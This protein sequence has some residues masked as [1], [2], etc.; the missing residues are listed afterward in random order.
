MLTDP[1]RAAARELCGAAKFAEH[2]IA[3]I[4]LAI[5][6]SGHATAVLDELGEETE[7]EIRGFGVR[8]QKAIEAWEKTQC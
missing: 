3:Q 1:E 7:S 2:A 5:A 4:T 8:L 6:L